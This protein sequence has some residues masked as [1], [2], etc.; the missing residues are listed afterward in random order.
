MDWTISSQIH[1][2][3]DACAYSVG[4]L[5]GD[6]YLSSEVNRKNGK[7]YPQYT[8]CFGQLER[9][10]VERVRDEIDS[11]FGSRYAIFPRTLN[12][13]K[14][15]HRM[16]V[17]RKDIFDFFAVNTLY[18]QEIPGH[19]FS[20][21]DDVK[22]DFIQGLMDADGYVSAREKNGMK[23]WNVGFA[24]N[25]ISIIR[26]LA[27]LLQSMGVHVGKIGEY[28]KAGY[29]VVYRINP[30]IRTFGEKGPFF[31]CQRK[32]KSIEAYV[33]HVR[34]SETKRTAPSTQGE[35]IVRQIAKAI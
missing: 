9:E 31:Y 2:Q 3:L 30:N 7:A 32:R 28:T 6:G 4:V 29:R 19:Y 5:L 33:S 15:F 24:N 17:C 34:G 10:I 35:D 16:H 21:S 25:K 12:S 14:I 18:K 26:G 22:R 23:W 13:G 8:V 20:T 11:V 27:S 1:E